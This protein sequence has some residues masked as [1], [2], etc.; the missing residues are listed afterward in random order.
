MK[1]RSGPWQ[2]EPIGEDN[3]IIAR[4]CGK[5][6]LAKT[7]ARGTR[8]VLGSDVSDESACEDEVLYLSG[9]HSGICGG[10]VAKVS[11]LTPGGLYM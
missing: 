1:V 2:G 8:T 9:R 4:C 3:C 6:V 7:I 5:E 10:R 11:S